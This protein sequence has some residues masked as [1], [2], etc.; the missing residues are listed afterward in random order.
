MEQQIVQDASVHDWQP[1]VILFP[2]IGLWLGHKGTHSRLIWP[3]R[4]LVRKSRTLQRWI[5]RRDSAGV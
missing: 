3:G 4:Y 5:Y 1:Y 2:R